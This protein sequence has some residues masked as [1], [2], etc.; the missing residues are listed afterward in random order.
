M[1]IIITT[2]DMR[3]S[4]AINLR[5]WRTPVILLAVVALSATII[6]RG[7]LGLAERWAT[8]GDER[9]RWLVEELRA[10]TDAERLELWHSTVD[11]LDQEVTD[12]QVQLWRLT[13][14]G[15]KIAERMGMEKEVLID[16]STVPLT[17]ATPTVTVN[18]DESISLLDTRLFK[19][20]ERMED[21]L[22]RINQIGFNISFAAMQWATV[23]IK[24]PIEGRFWQTSGYG[25]RRDPFSGRRAHHSGYDFAART[26]TP[27]LA[28]ADGII[29]HRG[30]LGS[31][32][33][34]I[35]IYH[36]DEISTLYGHL[37]D[38]RVQG[39]DFVTRGQVIALVGST[40]RS[41][42]PHLHYEIRTEGQPRPYSKAIKEIIAK[43]PLI[44]SLPAIQ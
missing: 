24:T 7:A 21:E 28:A 15:N 10:R 35:E 44:A 5:G 20:T 9:V 19:L 37:S 29:T 13:S 31:Y 3:R 22:L 4:L 36:G 1:N 25:T 41:T 30:R 27:V 6:Y 43:R 32:G 16:L 34:T 18:P 42:G 2:D 8:S 26:G 11:R 17:E 12:L 14:L 38:Y 40:G 33:K 39:G 23:P